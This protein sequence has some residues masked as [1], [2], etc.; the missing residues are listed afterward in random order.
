MDVAEE[1]VLVEDL[2]EVVVVLDVVHDCFAI[3]T[4]RVDGPM[5]VNGVVFLRGNGDDRVVGCLSISLHPKCDGIGSVDL[6]ARPVDVRFLDDADCSRV[7]DA[8]LELLDVS[9]G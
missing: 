9:L 4:V 3:G 1:M 7:L 2:F 8:G 5:D 6:D